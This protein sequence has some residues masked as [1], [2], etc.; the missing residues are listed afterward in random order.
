LFNVAVACLVLTALL[1]Y[2]NKRFIGLPTTIGVMAIALLLSV[3]LLGLDAAGFTGL[4]EAEAALLAQIDFSGVLMQGMLSILLF[5]GALH[6]DLHELR[7]ESARFALHR[8]QQL[9]QILLL[10]EPALVPPVNLAERPARCAC[11]RAFPT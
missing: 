11:R 4:H 9:Q 1:A 10:R 7:L 8:L 3:A 6:I 2:V 5:A